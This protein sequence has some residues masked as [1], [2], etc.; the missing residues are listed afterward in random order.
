MSSKN[1][2][3]L[4]MSKKA[5][6]TES[7]RRMFEDLLSLLMEKASEKDLQYTYYFLEKAE[8]TLSMPNQPKIGD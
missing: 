7:E 1:I 2:V 6:L 5:I 8:E 3:S 4:S